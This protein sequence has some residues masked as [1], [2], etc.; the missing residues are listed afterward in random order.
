MSFGRYLRTLRIKQGLIQEDISLLL[1]YATPQFVSNIERGISKIPMDSLPRFAKAYRIDLDKL[2][3]EF[4]KDK[5]IQ[6]KSEL[7]EIK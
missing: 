1:G 5:I 3:C 7:K 2:K 4:L 6:L